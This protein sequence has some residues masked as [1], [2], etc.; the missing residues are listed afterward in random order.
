MDVAKLKQLEKSECLK[1]A[2]LYASGYGSTGYQRHIS[3]Y[4]RWTA[5][6]DYKILDMGCGRGIAVAYLLQEKWN[7]F[8]TDITLTGVKSGMSKTT[9][10]KVFIEAPLWALPFKD[11][12]FGYTFSTDVLEHIPPELVG[13]AIEEIYRVTSKETLHVI[14]TRYSDTQKDLHLTVRSI[15]WWR[16]LFQQYNKKDIKCV[17]V[18]CDEFLMLHEQKAKEMA[19]PVKCACNRLFDNKASLLRHISIHESDAKHVFD[20]SHEDTYL[21]F[22]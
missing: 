21:M 14:A 9:F 4:V 17:V 15:W 19:I 7:V 13:S 16:E 20:L 5:H 22:R 1:Y 2:K 11:D 8:G 18:D 12:E 10:S 3:E 6:P